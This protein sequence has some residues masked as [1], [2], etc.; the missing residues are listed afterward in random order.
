MKIRLK[1]MLLMI[2]VSTIV[3][4][5]CKKTDIPVATTPMLQLLNRNLF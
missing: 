3:L 1:L 2:A 4:T 5:G